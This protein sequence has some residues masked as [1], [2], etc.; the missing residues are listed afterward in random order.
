MRRWP[1]SSPSASSASASAREASGGIF[2]IFGLGSNSD[3]QTGNPAFEEQIDEAEERAAADPKDDKALAD[4]V[5]LHYQAG[6]DA[7]EVDEAT[8]Q[9]SMTTESEEEYAQATSAWQDYLKVAKDPDPSTAAIANQAYGVILQFAEPTELA[10]IAEDAVIPAEISAEDTPGVG[11]WATVAQYAY[12]AGDTKTGDEAAKKAL[13]E[14]DSSQRKD[15]Q[16]QL[17]ATRKSAIQLQEQIKKEAEKGGG[18]GAFTNPLEE[19][20]GGGG[21]L[22]GA[23][24]TAL[25]GGTAPAP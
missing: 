24:G 13:A 19:G 21:A 12:F 18:E 25:P 9:I 6:N 5:Q 17:D 1:C 2:D 14:A 10:T 16:K 20:I 7:V 4:L 8:G 23:G 22:P 15:I 11:P 3:N